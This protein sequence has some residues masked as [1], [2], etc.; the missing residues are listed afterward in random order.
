MSQTA[1]VCE[2]MTTRT[3]C[4]NALARATW[5][6]TPQLRRMSTTCCARSGC[7]STRPLVL[8]L[9]ACLS[10]WHP[11]LLT[12]GLGEPTCPGG[13]RARAGRGGHR[14]ARRRARP[15]ARRLASPFQRYGV[16]AGAWP[17]SLPRPPG[18]GV[19]FA[20]VL[21]GHPTRII[22]FINRNLLAG[23]R[24]PG[25]PPGRRC[26]FALRRGACGRLQSVTADRPAYPVC[27]AGTP[28]TPRRTRAA[29][30]NRRP[31]GGPGGQRP[32][33]V[34]GRPGLLHLT[35]DGGCT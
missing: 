7:I 4:R 25:C 6:A 8:A 21:T 20:G 16:S 19:T 3:P 29:D 5:A 27:H 35:R 13:Y 26:A 12:L 15:A 10:C 30:Q 22:K 33:D 28:D 14:V 1:S 2:S 9:P 24:H 11:F 34:L 31:P 32:R 18:L 23:G 17:A